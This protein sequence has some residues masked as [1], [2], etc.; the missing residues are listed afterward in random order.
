LARLFSVLG[1][2]K[3]LRSREE[4]DAILRALLWKTLWNIFR[5]GENKT[6]DLHLP[7]SGHF[8]L[9]VQLFIYQSIRKSAQVLMRISMP[10][11]KG[12]P[13]IKAFHNWR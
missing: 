2:E 6:P 1:I 10:G 8:W 13:Q 4:R 11:T 9:Q 5:T 7:S 3:P 12:H